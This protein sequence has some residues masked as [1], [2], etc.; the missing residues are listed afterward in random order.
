MKMKGESSPGRG[1][2]RCKGLEVGMSWHIESTERPVWLEKR[3]P[4][5]NGEEMKSEALAEP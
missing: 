4:V 3:R 1:H 5:G 2:N